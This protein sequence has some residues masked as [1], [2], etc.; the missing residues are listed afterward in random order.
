MMRAAKKKKHRLERKA[1]SCEK[2][3][4]EMGL[5]YRPRYFTRS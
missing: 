4:E 3:R 5:E 2:V 1:E